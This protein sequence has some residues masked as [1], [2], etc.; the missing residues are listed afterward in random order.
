M[1]DTIDYYLD[2]LKKNS[3]NLTVQRMKLLEI[4][5]EHPKDHFSPKELEDIL[6][7]KNELTS[8]STIYRN[9]KVFERF[10]FIKSIALDN[11]IKKY[12][13]NKISAYDV[14]LHAHLIC[15]DC[16]GIIDY[17]PEIDIEEILE[18]EDYKVFKV[19]SI[20]INIYGICEKCR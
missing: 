17:I 12:E 19:E 8:F 3:E 7:S 4:F 15:K 9:L 14:K 6:K 1:I 20:D 16:G 2:I 18:R 10:D 11:G 13:L 5:L